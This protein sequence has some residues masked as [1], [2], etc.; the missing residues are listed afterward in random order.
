MVSLGPNFEGSIF[1]AAVGLPQRAA[2]RVYNATA[3]ILAVTDRAA[4]ED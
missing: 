3:I 2:S 4:V 1:A